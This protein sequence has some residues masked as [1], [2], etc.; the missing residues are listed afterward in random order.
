MLH[1][2]LTKFVHDLKET[3]FINAKQE[4]EEEIRAMINNILNKAIKSS[5]GKE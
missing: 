2:Y 5:M 4:L 1:N 3:N